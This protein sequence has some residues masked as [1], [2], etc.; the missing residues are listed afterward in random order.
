MKVR[1]EKGGRWKMEGGRWTKRALGLKVVL[2]GVPSSPPSIVFLL[3][4]VGVSFIVCCLLRQSQGAKL[5]FF[6][7]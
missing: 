3:S 7:S 6:V 5:V 1:V 4:F 2:R